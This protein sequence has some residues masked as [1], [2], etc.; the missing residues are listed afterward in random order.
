MDNKVRYFEDDDLSIPFYFDRIKRV[1]IAFVDL[2][3]EIDNFEDAIELRN[4]FKII[5]EGTYIW[6][7]E[8]EWGLKLTSERD[9]INSK[10]HKFFNTREVESILNYAQYLKEDSIYAADFFEVFEIYNYAEKIDEE[11]FLRLFRMTNLSIDYLLNSKYFIKS[12][13]EFMKKEFLSN[14]TNLEILLNNYIQNN[15]ECKKYF[16]EN[17]SKEEWNELVSKYIG[18][19]VANENY[20]KILMSSIRRMGNKYF[21]ISDEQKIKIARILKERSS[22]KFIKHDDLSIQI[23]VFKSKKNFKQAK[24]RTLED[25]VEIIQK[26]IINSMIGEHQKLTI[27]DKV[28]IDEDV[29]KQLNDNEGFLRFMLLHLDIFSKRNI[30][31]LSSFPLLESSV[32]EQST[33]VKTKDYYPKSIMF[34]VKQEKMRIRLFFL[35]KQLKN[36]SLSIESV[37]TWFFT[38]FLKSKYQVNYFMF[39]FSNE[40]ESDENKIGTIFRVEESIRKQL[41]L[42]QKHKEIS[43]DLYN[44][45]QNTPQFKEI[46]SFIPNKYIYVKRN[47]E[48]DAILFY[49]FSDQSGLGYISKKLQE[50]NL[51]ELINSRAVSINDFREQNRSKIE[52]LLK[53][54]ILINRTELSLSDRVSAMVLRDLYYYRETSYYNSDENEKLFLNELINN[55]W[56]DIGNTV[57]SKNEMEYLDYILNDKR[58]DNSM[59][60]RN[61]YQ[62]GFPVYSNVDQYRED[63]SHAL[64]ILIIYLGKVLEELDYY[65]SINNEY[66]E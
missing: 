16:P 59:G 12:Y 39:K 56:V 20:L 66:Q 31:E 1:L 9:N 22:N 37:F 47:S 24:K 26:Y 45:M 40:T 8:E 34:F 25:N 27:Y 11:D 51:Y 41:F 10:L 55:E 5:D 19:P 14:S 58:H 61:K 28:L 23:E 64:S 3:C 42:F 48:L 6:D 2:K 30:V 50:K 35:Q 52:W 46:K 43:I 33:Y 17:I 29:F 38:E 57:F 63:Y 49:L 36:V 65:I 62:H 4:T 15:M 21:T 13:P 60:L 44:I 7:K 54:K 18:N 32:I 53:H